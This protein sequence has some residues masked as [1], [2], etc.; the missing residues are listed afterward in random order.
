M[1]STKPQEES[2]WRSGSICGGNEWT[3]ERASTDRKY[4]SEESATATLKP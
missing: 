2:Q 1:Q 3:V 4:Q